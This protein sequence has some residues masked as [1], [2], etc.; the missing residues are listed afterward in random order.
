MRSRLLLAL[1]LFLAPG[2]SRAQ[3]FPCDGR[4][5]VAIT[6]SREP[7]RLFHLDWPEAAQPV[8]FHRI[9]G[10]EPPVTLNALGFRVTDGYLYGVH[11]V[12]HRLYRVGA[13]GV[14]HSLGPLSLTPGYGYFAGPTF[15]LLPSP[16]DW[17]ASNFA[18][19]GSAEGWDRGGNSLY[20]IPGY[21]AIVRTKTGADIM[22]FGTALLFP[23]LVLSPLYSTLPGSSPAHVSFSAS[24]HLA[25]V[26]RHSRA[27]G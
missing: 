9:G 25:P 24:P 3:P 1:L 8:V 23:V 17:Q 18:P 15:T 14:A 16:V 7:S 11:P 22:L 5:I 26:A 20:V 21:P 12:E 27:T 19:P 10:Q 4:P 6:P 13:D 2:Y